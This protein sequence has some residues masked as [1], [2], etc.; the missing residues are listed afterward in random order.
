MPKIDRFI[1][2]DISLMEDIGVVKAETLTQVFTALQTLTGLPWPEVYRS[3]SVY[4][5]FNYD[6]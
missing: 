6:N 1:I 3:Y 5:E 4:R 2:Y